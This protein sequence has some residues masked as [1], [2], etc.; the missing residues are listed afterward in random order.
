M[1]CRCHKPQK[2][3]CCDGGYKPPRDRRC[4]NLD[5]TVRDFS[6]NAAG[7]LQ[8]SPDIVGAYTGQPGAPLILGWGL[9]TTAGLV[10]DNVYVQTELPEDFIP[11][12]DSYLDLDFLLQP[13]P[14]PGVQTYV[15]FFIGVDNR[16]SGQTISTTFPCVTDSGVGFPVVPD[17]ILIKKYS[18]SIPLNSC[19][20]TQP[21]YLFINIQRTTPLAGADYPAD[22][23]I[24]AASLRYNCC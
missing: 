23:Y 18:L 11:C 4:Q 24:S 17:S 12:C 3:N 6:S 15:R 5:F 22:V 8:A 9:T 13:A 20:L 7:V 21:G 1:K 2:S 19:S 14:V 10:T 16:G